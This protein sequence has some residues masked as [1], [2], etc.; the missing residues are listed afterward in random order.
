MNATTCSLNYFSCV[1]NEVN[2]LSGVQL[3]LDWQLVTPK[4]LHYLQTLK[5]HTNHCLIVVV[6]FENINALPTFTMA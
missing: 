3:I 1:Y 5:G 6:T 4:W 2:K